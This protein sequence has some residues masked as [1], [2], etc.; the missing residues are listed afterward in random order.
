MYGIEGRADAEVYGIEGRADAEHNRTL[1]L[2]NLIQ[3]D[4]IGSP[5]R[6][7]LRVGLH[8]ATVDVRLH[9]QSWQGREYNAFGAASRVSVRVHHA[10]E[11]HRMFLSDCV[12]LAQGFL[13]EYVA[14]NYQGDARTTHT[15]W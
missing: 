15:I 1:W 5:E 4:A 8:C 14:A 11:L 7:A 13:R 12:A 10:K 6:L 2:R 3:S 9:H